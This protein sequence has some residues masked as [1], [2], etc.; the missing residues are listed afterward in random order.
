MAMVD[1][2]FWHNRRVFL[3]GH[4][5]FKGS[6]LCLWLHRLGAEVYGYALDPPTDPSLFRT[7]RVDELVDSTTGDIRDLAALRSAV[8]RA[9][10]EVVIHMAAQTLVRPSFDDPVETFSTNVMGTVHLLEAVREVPSVKAVVVVTSDKCYFNEEW[11]WGYREDSR[12]GGEDPYSSSKGCAELATLAYRHSFYD[13]ARRPGAAV[14]ATARAG[15]VIGGGDWATDRLVPDILKSLL[16]NEPTLIRHPQ[17]TRPWQHV[18]EPLNGY[19]MLAERLCSP[20]GQQFANAW[21]FGPPEDSERTVGWIIARI[22]DLWGVDFEWVRDER[23]GPPENTFLKLD[24]AKARARLHWQ[25]RLDLPTTLEWIVDW[26]RGYQR[27]EDTRGLTLADI[28]RF[29]GLPLGSSTS[30]GPR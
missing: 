12:L 25:P 22:Y 14:V 9:Q 15:N 27:G 5:G 6:W 29:C 17:A 2:Q 20:D 8:E 19:L 1:P 28:D 10:P 13:P 7:A 30:G 16:R 21:N 24:A 3:T 4:T 11:V 23:P 18:M 26:T